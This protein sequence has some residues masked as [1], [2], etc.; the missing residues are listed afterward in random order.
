MDFAVPAARPR[1]PFDLAPARVALTYW[2]RHGRVPDLRTPTTFTERVQLRKLADRDIRMPKLAD[3]VEVKRI[4]ADRLGRDW[5]IPTLWHGDALPDAP[6]W[7]YPF[8][9]KSRH[10]CNQNAFIHNDSLG[11]DRLQRR[12]AGWMH[13]YGGWLDEWLYA[14]VPMGV[15]VEPFMG[16]G[17]TLPVDYKFYVFGGRV[18]YV[19]VHLGRGGRHRWIVLDRD[20]RR[21]SSPSADADPPRPDCLSAMIAAAEEMGTGFDFVRVD[22][23]D[24]GGRPM[25]GEMTFYPGSGLDRFDPPALDVAM[26]RRWAEASSGLQPNRAMFPAQPWERSSGSAGAVTSEVAAL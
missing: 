25:F 5:V 4:V 2:W 21:V 12:V 6:A 9:L 7:P 14:H 17:R 16:T 20:W 1:P 10:G 26:G 24:I 3:K 23:Y 18:A 11:W 15:L 19:Q 22:L 8:V 13:P